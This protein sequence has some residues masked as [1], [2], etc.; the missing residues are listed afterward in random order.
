MWTETQK[1]TAS[2]GVAIDQ[3]G[4]SVS[5]NNDIAFVSSRGDAIGTV[6]VFVNTNGVWTETQKLT[7]SDGVFGDRFGSSV[8]IGD[9]VAIIG[10][11][12]IAFF[13]LD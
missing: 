5:I 13:V 3:F 4:Y 12:I 9:N 7:A 10:V 6:Y 11:I 8:S 1:L 2:D